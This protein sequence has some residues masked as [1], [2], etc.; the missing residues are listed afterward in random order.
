MKAKE[1]IEF[2]KLTSRKTMP[3]LQFENEL[4]KVV[5]KH[6]ERRQKKQETSVKQWID[7]KII[8]KLN[9]LAQYLPSDGYS[10]GGVR[11]III[12]K[13][14]QGSY[15]TCNDYSRSCKYKATHVFVGYKIK[16]DDLKNYSV[17][18]GVITY[19]YKNQK[20]KVK[21]CYW[22]EGRGKKQNFKLVKIE[23][24][25]CYNYHGLDKKNVL[26]KGTAN[27]KRDKEQKKQAE[28]IEKNK[29]KALNC[30]YSFS[31]SLNAGNCEA[32]TKAFI[33][34]CRLN[35]NRKYKGKTLLKIASK[36]SPASIHFVER[37]LNYKAI[38]LC[39]K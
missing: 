18:G 13:Y 9:Y 37:M 31:D 10:M 8:D 24:Y 4:S 38:I 29:E 35:A 3:F 12:N 22:L 17:I 2:K 6:F 25:I 33:L 20:S 39:S 28:K 5:K 19:I 23:G 15:D 11:K 21:K 30:L 36:K 14:L 27:E 32:G 16:A 34:R 1:L 7:K 26:E